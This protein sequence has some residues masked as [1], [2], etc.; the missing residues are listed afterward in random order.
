MSLF[1]IKPFVRDTSLRSALG[2]MSLATRWGDFL[3]PGITVLTRDLYDVRAIHAV[4]S[5]MRGKAPSNLFARLRRREVD[6]LVGRRLVRILRQHRLPKPKRPTQQMTF[7]QR[8]GSLF[9]YFGVLR[10]R[11]MRSLPSYREMIFDGRRSW[12]EPSG[13]RARRIRHFNWYRRRRD[14]LLVDLVPDGVASQLR[15]RRWWLTGRGAP[16][17]VPAA[18]IVVREL[19]F[20]FLIWETAF[21]AAAWLLHREGATAVKRSRKSHTVEEFIAALLKCRTEPS[22]QGVERLLRCALSLH[23]S[24]VRRRARAWERDALDVLRGM[25]DPIRFVRL[26][27]DQTIADFAQTPSRLLLE[28]LADLHNTYA[29]LQNKSHAIAVKSF[30][31]PERGLRFPVFTAELNSRR[32]GLHGYRFEASIGLY[33]SRKY[34]A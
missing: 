10:L 6:R 16:A 27:N 12:A 25:E 21:E 20:F 34:E 3:F 19:E 18:I 5:D 24:R 14:Q 31:P 30:S 2:F 32:W 8:Y 28:R 7:W 13:A 23:E 1:L 15:P 9:E 26:H 33:E 29:T 22:T 4:A 17:G 11:R